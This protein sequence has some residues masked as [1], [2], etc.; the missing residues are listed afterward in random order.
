MKTPRQMATLASSMKAAKN[1][2]Y[3]AEYCVMVDLPQ[4]VEKSLLQAA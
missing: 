2:L 4:A 3:P 1:Y